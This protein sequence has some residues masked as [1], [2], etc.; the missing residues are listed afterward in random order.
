MPLCAPRRRPPPPSQGLDPLTQESLLVPDG[1]EAFQN[2]FPEWCESAVQMEPPL[3]GLTSLRISPQ[4]TDGGGQ[5]GLLVDPD[6]TLGHETPLDDLCFP[7]EILPHLFLGNAQNSSDK[8]A[9][10]RH[11]IRVSLNCARFMRERER[12]VDT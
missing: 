8:E 2:L 12:V 10:N 6:S 9:L 7:V 1:Y 5:R 3:V 11:K 4:D